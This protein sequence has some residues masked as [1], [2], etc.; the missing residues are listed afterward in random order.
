MT[1]SIPW[2]L[3]AF[4]VVGCDQFDLDDY[5]PDVTFQRME[6]KAIDFQHIGTDFVFVV[7][8]PNPVDIGLSSFSWGL[9]LEDV[10]L[11]SGEN[12]DGFQ[13][14]AVG[15]SELRLPVD[16]VWADAWATVQA[17][18]G[19]DMVGFGL[20]GHFGFMTPL[21]EARLP[22]D[23]GGEFPAL[24]T[25][26]FRPAKLRVQGLNLLTQSATVALDMAVDNDHGSTLS[27]QGAAYTI[28]LGSV[29]VGAGNTEFLGD[30]AGAT[31]GTLTIPFT[32]NLLSVGTTVANA[33]IN[34]TP[35]PVQFDAA[36]DVGTPFG[37]VPLDVLSIGTAPIE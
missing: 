23:E 9:D 13:L 1:R 37:V 12:P 26:T 5:L 27:F 11:L 33:I 15:E 18:R 14:E 10:N 4:T 25:P 2:P 21:G 3:L 30:V 34:K 36:I 35:L 28:K 7:D 16:L 6:V 8:N 29:D 17:T 19:Q 32:V 24:R 20:D 31:E 22:Y